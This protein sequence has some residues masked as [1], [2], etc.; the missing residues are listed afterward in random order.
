MDVYV[1]AASDP[2]S[3]PGL[4]HL[5]ERWTIYFNEDEIFG[6]PKTFSIFQLLIKKG[7]SSAKSTSLVQ[8]YQLYVSNKLVNY[9]YNADLAS[10]IYDVQVF[11]RGV[12][13]IFGGFNDKLLDFSTNISAKL[14]QDIQSV[15][16]GS[17]E[18][19]SV[20]KIRYF[21]FFQA[22]IFNDRIDMSVI[23]YY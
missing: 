9:T 7:I 4:A 14:A 18:S 20:I 2:E 5:N 11:P 12:R 8:L 17:S 13:L 16:P 22:L 10:I 23:I 21:D 19:S 6:Q 1:G 15:F 3:I